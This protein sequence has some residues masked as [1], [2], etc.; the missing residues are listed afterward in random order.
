MK[1]FA[2]LLIAFAVLASVAA[3]AFSGCSGDA[4]TEKSYSGGEAEIEKITVQVEDRELEISASD[5]N[6]IYIDYFDGEKEYLDIAL[7]ES[8]ELTVKLL[9]NK[10]WTDYIGIK[11]AKE[12]RKIKIKLPDNLITA[13]FV[14]TTNENI[15]VSSLSFGGRVDL[16]INGG[17]IF[18]E[19]VNVGSALSLT[20]KNGDI[21]GAIVGGWDDFAMHCTIKSGACN[22]PLSKESGAKKLFADCN[23]GDINIEFVR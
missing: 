21:T 5:D 7:S 20:A 11:A 9:Y 3:F 23:N 14:S 13:L 4:F 1:K 18:L 15:K 2:G 8:G 10:S 16:N 12:F 6:R 17:S 19:R 22:L